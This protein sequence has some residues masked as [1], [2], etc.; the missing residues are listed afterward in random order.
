M[1]KTLIQKPKIGELAVLTVAALV[2]AEA[3]PI[4][5]AGA[6]GLLTGVVTLTIYVA[7]FLIFGRLFREYIWEPSL[8]WFRAELRSAI[9]DEAQKRGDGDAAS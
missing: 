3:L 2:V 6:T 9:R 5:H 1:K 4:P 8:R 7:L